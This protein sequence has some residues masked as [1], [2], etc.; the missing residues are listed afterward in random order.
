VVRMSAARFEELRVDFGRRHDHAVWTAVTAEELRVDGRQGR[1]D[2]DFSA[3][4]VDEQ[5]INMS[6]HTNR[7]G[8]YPSE[9]FSEREPSK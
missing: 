4:D 2:R 6:Y 9:P 1:D 3:N 8:S 7:P 5:R